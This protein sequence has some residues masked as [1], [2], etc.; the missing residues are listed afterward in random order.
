MPPIALAL[1]A[2]IDAQ[3]ALGTIIGGSTIG[4]SVNEN[5]SF[6][7]AYSSLM[8]LPST[9]INPASSTITGMT[10]SVPLVVKNQNEFPITAPML[11]F[12][13]RFAGGTGSLVSS[14]TEYLNNDP[15]IPAKNGR[16][17][18]RKKLLLRGKIDWSRLG[19]G[20]QP[21]IN[22]QRPLIEL[23]GT[24]KA[25]LGYGPADVKFILP[26]LPFQFGQ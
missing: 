12:E 1:K 8:D 3:H 17:A 25:D 22:N 6:I 26:S 7:T 23:R 9:I 21:L 11:T 10:F 19:S 24:L 5:R 2:A 15:Q 18:G 4:S 14:N 16:L 20:L 13:A